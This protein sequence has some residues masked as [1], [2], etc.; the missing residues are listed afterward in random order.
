MIR[1]SRNWMTQI[2]EYLLHMHCPCCAWMIFLI[3]SNYLF[4][5]GGN[6]NPS[7]TRD[8]TLRDVDGYLLPVRVNRHVAWGDKKPSLLAA[9]RSIKVIS[10]PLDRSIE[11]NITSSPE[12]IAA[13]VTV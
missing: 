13:T 7:N 8:R 3:Y 10:Y 12:F 4:L 2:I 6:F 5:G 1:N 11:E 9:Q